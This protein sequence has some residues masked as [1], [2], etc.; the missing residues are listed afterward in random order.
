MAADCDS[1][2]H[3]RQPAYLAGLEKSEDYRP[4]PCRITSAIILRQYVVERQEIRQS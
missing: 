1:S 2:Q 4:R 3:Q